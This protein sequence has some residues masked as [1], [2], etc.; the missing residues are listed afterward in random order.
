MTLRCAR[1]LVEFGRDFGVDVNELVVREPGGED[2]YGLEPDLTL[3]PEP[4]VRDAVVLEMPFSPLCRPDCLGLC[5]ICGGNRN[6]GEC[7]GHDA[8]DPRWAALEGLFVDTPAATDTNDTTDTME[9]A[10][11]DADR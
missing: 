10:A 2:D 5:E 11:D 4:L 8:T 7:P 9:T 3:D 6:L 1:C